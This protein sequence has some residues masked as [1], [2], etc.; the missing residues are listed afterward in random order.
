MHQ[1]NILYLS[2]LLSIP[3]SSPALWLK[4]LVQGI[5][6]IPWQN[7]HLLKSLFLFIYLFFEE[8]VLRNLDTHIPRMSYLIPYEKIN[9]KGIKSK[10][11]NYKTTKIKSKKLANETTLNS[12]T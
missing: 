2:K 3:N 9:S 12:N 5:K 10:T 4:K 8:S 11:K 6:T 7:H 1:Q